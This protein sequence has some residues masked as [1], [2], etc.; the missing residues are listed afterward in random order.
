MRFEV[1]MNPL[2]KPKRLNAVK[3]YSEHVGTNLQHEG[4]SGEIKPL[5][6]MMIPIAMS[7]GTLFMKPRTLFTTVTF[8][9]YRA[10]P[11]GLFAFL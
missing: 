9:C 7:D 8:S 2:K 11:Q 3:P 4:S 1:N 6:N 10:L 5:Y